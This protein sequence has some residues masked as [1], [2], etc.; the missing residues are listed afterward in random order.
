M[1]ARLYTYNTKISGTCSLRS[2]LF[3][4]RTMCHVVEFDPKPLH[5]KFVVDEITLGQVFFTE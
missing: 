5:V 3:L 1:T 2:T 4:G